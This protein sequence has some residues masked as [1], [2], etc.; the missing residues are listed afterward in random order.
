VRRLLRRLHRT[1]GVADLPQDWPRILPADAP[2]ATVE[3]WEQTFA[4][5][6]PSDWPDGIDRSGLVLDILRVL[7][8][9]P[10]AAREAGE[11]LLP[12]LS[13]KHG[14]N[15]KKCAAGAG[16]PSLGLRPRYGRPA[17]AHSHP[18]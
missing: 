4:Q 1:P 16:R 12:K 2:L 18:D 9:G 3:R 10:D 13:Q 6:M 15:Y 17:P 14:A 7:E 5:A 8:K 11:K